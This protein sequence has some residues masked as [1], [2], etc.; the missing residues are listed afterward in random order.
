MKK[1]VFAAAAA[2][3]L[4]S[5][6]AL[7][8]QAG[9]GPWTLYLRAVNLHSVDQ[10]S[11]GLG[12]GVNDKIIPDISVRYAF[13]QNFA[14]ELL[15]TV[16]QKHSVRSNGTKIGTLRHL[17]PTLL[18]Q[19]H[20]N[21]NGFKPYVGAGINYTR[22]S[23]VRLPT[24]VSISKNSW[25][26]AFQ[27]GVDIPLNR[28]LYLNLDVK[29]IYLDTNVSAGGTRLGTLNVNPVLFGAGLGWRF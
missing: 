22:F 20:L 10:D 1:N 28:N 13:D 29:K 14:T 16:P 4:V 18:G 24:G 25:G 12:L 15:L 23:S 21:L 9:E 5:G 6:V 17:P 2:C 8:Q 27:L 19:Y 26:P 7:A 3:I 11:T